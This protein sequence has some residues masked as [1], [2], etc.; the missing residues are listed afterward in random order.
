[1]IPLCAIKRFSD[2]P[3]KTVKTRKRTAVG[4]PDPGLKTPEMPNQQWF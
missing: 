1:M 2:M 3:R 4:W